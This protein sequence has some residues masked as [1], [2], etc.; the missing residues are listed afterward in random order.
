M[1]STQRRALAVAALL[2]LLGACG[3]D[4]SA[5]RAGA[6][7]QDVEDREAAEHDEAPGSAPGKDVRGEEPAAP[8]EPK[9][10]KEQKGPEAKGPGAP[11]SALRAELVTLL[12]EHVFLSGMATS[13]TLRGG[14]GA[15]I[16][17]AL[18]SNSAALADAVGR[19]YGDAAAQR[20]LEVWRRQL[21]L[22]VAFTQATAAGDRAAV[23]K[24]RSD[25][26]AYRGELA[27][28]LSEVN[29]NLTPDM[30]GD[31]LK[32]HITSFSSLVRAQAKGDESQLMKLK[33]AADR[34]RVTAAIL[35]AGIVKDKE[36]MFPGAADGM[37]ATLRAT[38]TAKL[39]EHVYLTGLAA[40]AVLADGDAKTAV[41]TVHENTVELS[42][43]VGTVYGDVAAR[44]FLVLWRQHV[45]F[46]V[47]FARAVG[48][49]DQGGVERATAG[50]EGSTT[51]VAT[52]FNANNPNLAKGA[53]A[54]H[55]KAHVDSMLAAIRAQAAGDPTQVAK[56][57]A[58][59]RRMP[60]MA[61]FLAEGIAKQFKAEFA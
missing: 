23:D 36:D 34:S 57:Q 8:K 60:A 31:D 51:A 52:F 11:A 28:L 39:Q 46:L 30:V 48:G 38:L 40:G 22:F 13:T 42:N 37:G 17:G 49:R 21:G 10:Q 55:M 6:Q 9:E 61:A 33:E 26:D 54:D 59:A 2:A 35:T 7:R 16:T 41:D 27:S 45:G 5:E 14:D 29:P 12:Q 4:D 43:V 58:A 47:D 3:G 56:L 32:A 24:V 25:L 1:R 53:V 19:I 44:R 50:L 15:A 20:F 18:D